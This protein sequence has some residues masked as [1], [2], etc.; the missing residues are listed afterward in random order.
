VTCTE[1]AFGAPGIGTVARHALSQRGL[2]APRRDE[3]P[4]PLRFAGRFVEQ[5]FP[6]A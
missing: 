4:G 5:R 3:H 2:A 1:G 6:G